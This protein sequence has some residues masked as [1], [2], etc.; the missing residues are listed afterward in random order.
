[1]Q[2]AERRSWIWPR[3]PEAGAGPSN[4]LA[5]WRHRLH[6]LAAQGG[7]RLQE[8]GPVLGEPLTSLH[9]PARRGAPRLL[10]A[11]GF[12]GEEPAGPWGV[13][14]FM[15]ALPSAWRG[16]VDLRLLPLVNVS[17]FSAGQRFNRLGENPNRGYLPA[18]PE[19]PSAEG[20]VLKRHARR[21]TAWARDGLLTC[22]EDV[23][24]AHTY[25]YTFEPHRRPGALT[26]ALLSEAA[27]HF[28][29][30]PDGEVD[31]C[32]VRGGCVF[33]HRDSSFEA[34]LT[35]RGVAVAACYETPGQQPF[36]RRVA[37][38]AAVM[39]AFVAQRLRASASSPAS[40][41]PAAA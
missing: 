36:E 34:W 1:M 41:R 10:I 32:P 13:L 6:E 12:H 28:E 21:L 5:A 23:L 15:A 18:F 8:L 25:A 19:A 20:R 35:A 39:R 40:P 22:H 17:G 14:A 7:W 33:N 2:E 3:S 9:L 24:L 26:R 11:S 16:A 30:H 29:L 38:Q 37:A 4:D 27:R 31:G